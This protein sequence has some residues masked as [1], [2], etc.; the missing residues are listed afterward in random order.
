MKTQRLTRFRAY[1]LGRAGSFF[2]YFNGTKFT[3]IET[4]ITD[5]SKQ[6]LAKEMAE[7]GVTRV[8]E[9]HIT[10]WDTD[11]C[12]KNGLEY[13]LNHLKPSE[14]ECPGYSPKT[15]TAKEC[16]ALIETYKKSQERLAAPVSVALKVIN[17]DYINGLKDAEGYAYND[18]FYWPR[19]IGENSNNNSTVKL[20]RGGS[21]NV[22]SLGDVECTVI[23]GRLSACMKFSSEID[24]MILAHHGSDNSMCSK[25][26]LK[27]TVPQVAICSSDYDNKFDHPSESVRQML[28]DLEIPIYTTKT[29]DVLILSYGAHSGAYKVVN[30]KGDSTEI[31]SQKYFRSKKASIVAKSEASVINHYNRPINPFKKFM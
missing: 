3:L 1:Q 7:C 18:V 25:G 8:D 31:S 30:L 9:L 6:T 29:G 15:D 24:V 22:A 16:L 21:F 26:F 14:I 28:Y 19:E 23:G 20:F 10:S 4:M 17:P 5:M 12:E 11:H 27:K 2:S 13:I